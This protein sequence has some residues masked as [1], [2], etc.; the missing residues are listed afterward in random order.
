MNTTTTEPP[1]ANKP[2]KSIAAI[3]LRVIGWLWLARVWYVYALTVYDAADP[4][5]IGEMGAIGMSLRDNWGFSSHTASMALPV[6]GGLIIS[7]IG[8]L[9]SLILFRIARA[10]TRRAQ[11]KAETQKAT[12]ESAA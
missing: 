10:L 8:S 2:K 6:V 5:N 12:N 11:K 3:V 9:L 1:L 7:I 4:R